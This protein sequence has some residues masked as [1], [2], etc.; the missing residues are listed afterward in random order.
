MILHTVNKTSAL[1]K[2]QNLMAADDI[3]LLIE[4]GVYLALQGV[5]KGFAL[6]ADVEAR[7]IADRMPEGIRIIDYAGFVNLT[8]EADKVC[9][10]F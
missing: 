10:W 1:A 2:C 3:M 9:A 4:D 6:K 8:A 5:N 7:G